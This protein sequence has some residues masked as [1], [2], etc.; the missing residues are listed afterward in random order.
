ML[1]GPPQ[2]FV[3][4]AKMLRETESLHTVSTTAI[5]PG[6]GAAPKRY[7]RIGSSY[8]PRSMAD[9]T[10]LPSGRGH[11]CTAARHRMLRAK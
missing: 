1:L 5:S 2:T 3:G 11:L 9:V 4:V 10:Q 7:F 8:S 6:K